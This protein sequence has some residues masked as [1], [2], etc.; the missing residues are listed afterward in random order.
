MGSYIAIVAFAILCAINGFDVFVSGNWSVSS[1]LTDYISIPVFLALY[2]GHR[3]YHY[4]DEWWRQ[5]DDIDL[6]SG[7]DEVEAEY[8]GEEENSSPKRSIINRLTNRFAQ[9]TTSY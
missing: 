1:F 3:I 8:D 4:K 5:V 2:F 9:R 6:Q 7:L